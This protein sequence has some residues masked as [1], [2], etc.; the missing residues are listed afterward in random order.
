MK[1]NVKLIPTNGKSLTLKYKRQ[2]NE[3]DSSWVH[4][5]TVFCSKTVILLNSSVFWD[6]MPRS[7][8]IVNEHFGATCCFPLWDQKV[9][10]TETNSYVYCLLDADFLFGLIIYPADRGSMFPWND[11]WCSPDYMTFDPRTLNSQATAVWTSNPTSTKDTPEVMP[12]ILL[13]WPTTSEADAGLW[14]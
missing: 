7:Q 3:N 4:V 1:T 13:C 2:F 8:V 11:S 5:L 14:Q 12:H 10:Q 9:T 6:V